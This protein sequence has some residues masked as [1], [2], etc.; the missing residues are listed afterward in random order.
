MSILTDIT[1]PPI[2]KILAAPVREQ[3]LD[4]GGM[5]L[6]SNHRLAIW[7]SSVKEIFL[8]GNYTIELKVVPIN[9]KWL[10]DLFEKISEI[11]YRTRVDSG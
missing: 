3:R 9:L 8:V 11:K 10:G 2:R 4:S 5:A 7:K 6:P 1:S